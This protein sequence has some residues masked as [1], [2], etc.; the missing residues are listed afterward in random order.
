[1]TGA[2]FSPKSREGE[3]SGVLQ[4]RRNDGISRGSAWN[5]IRAAM[6]S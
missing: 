1:M 2:G 6:I 4:P 3:G 5:M